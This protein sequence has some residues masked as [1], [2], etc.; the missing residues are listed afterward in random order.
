MGGNIHSWA[1]SPLGAPRP[2]VAPWN[3]H[4][5]RMNVFMHKAMLYM[6]EPLY[7]SQ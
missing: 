2:V 4:A 6:G 7:L 3:V 1:G 5:N